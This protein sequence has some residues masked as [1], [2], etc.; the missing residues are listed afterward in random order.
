MVTS[1]IYINLIFT[2]MNNSGKNKKISLIGFYY[3]ITSLNKIGSNINPYGTT[4]RTSTYGL[5][6]IPIFTRWRRFVR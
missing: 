2:I 4:V 3:I 1:Y 6:V 5:N